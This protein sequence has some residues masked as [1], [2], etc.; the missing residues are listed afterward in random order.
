MENT[1]EILHSENSVYE[2][3]QQETAIPQKNS[4]IHGIHTS[5]SVEEES[6]WNEDIQEIRLY[7]KQNRHSP[8]LK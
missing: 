6:T 8:I 1:Q 3:D 2:I 5:I 4:R 7:H